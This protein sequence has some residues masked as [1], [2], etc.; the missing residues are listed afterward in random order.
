M[1]K[2]CFYYPN[3]KLYENVK[4][5]QVRIIIIDTWLL[6]K[7]AGGVCRPYRFN[8]CNYAFMNVTL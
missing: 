8:H 7:P 3:T 5:A 4:A 2:N 6:I 1:E